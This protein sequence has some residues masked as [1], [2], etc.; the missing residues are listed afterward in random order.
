MELVPAKIHKTGIEFVRGSQTRWEDIEGLVKHWDL[1]FV[2][3]AGKDWAEF[4][5]RNSTDTVVIEIP[6]R[7]DTLGVASIVANLSDL[8][9]TK[10]EATKCNDR[11]IIKMQWK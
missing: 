1:R 11:I 4:G 9:P 6:Q 10:T 2:D 8:K 3:V 7:E 5:W